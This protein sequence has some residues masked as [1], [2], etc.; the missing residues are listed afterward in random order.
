MARARV[1]RQ[2]FLLSFL[3]GSFEPDTC[4][5]VD[6]DFEMMMCESHE[7]MLGPIL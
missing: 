3:V 5:G 4:G 6:G 1:A 7:S 2:C